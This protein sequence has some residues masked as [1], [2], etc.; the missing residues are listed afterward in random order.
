MGA[1]VSSIYSYLK[2]PKGGTT[3]LRNV[4]F[5]IIPTYC[6]KLELQLLFPKD[7]LIDGKIR[8]L[9]QSVPKLFFAGFVSKGG[10]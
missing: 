5:V 7:F 10:S 3:Y 4:S 6:L 1:L 8:P 2:V 9:V